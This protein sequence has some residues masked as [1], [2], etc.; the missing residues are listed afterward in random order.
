MSFGGRS[1]E[2]SEEEDPAASWLLRGSPRTPL[3]N[4]S[5]VISAGIS[6][7]RSFSV[8]YTEREGKRKRKKQRERHNLKQINEI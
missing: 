1:A 3:T 7:S 8:S 5:K 2:V 6:V 4:V